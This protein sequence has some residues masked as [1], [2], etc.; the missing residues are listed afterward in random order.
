MK[1]YRSRFWPKRTIVLVFLFLLIYAALV[2]I[3]RCVN[4]VAYDYD[5]R[6]A[7]SSFPLKSKVSL[8]LVYTMGYGAYPR[9]PGAGV[10]SF[11][12]SETVL[13]IMCP[14][15][16]GLV[17]L[18]IYA[19]DIRSGMAPVIF[20]RMTRGRYFLVNGAGYVCSV[21][22]LTVWFLSV[23]LAFS[24]LGAAI[25]PAFGI[26]VSSDPIPWAEVLRSLSL[27]C[28]LNASLALVSYSFALLLGR[29]KIIAQLMFVALMILVE[30]GSMEIFSCAPLDMTYIK[31][32]LNHPSMQVYW[33][34]IIVSVLVAAVLFGIKFLVSAILPEEKVN[35]ALL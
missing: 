15:F 27:Q 32:P 33:G 29:L 22:L 4:T 25:L 11:L 2:T 26:N 35:E 9:Y 13:Q 8:W 3:L 14:V 16:F 24:L 6:L 23:Q 18:Q 12:V 20:S 17:G 10:V 1:Y 7:G 30:L 5:L 28:M 34:W 21:V 31:C 19:E